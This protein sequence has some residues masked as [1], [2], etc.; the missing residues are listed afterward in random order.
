MLLVAY[1]L[2]LERPCE[3]LAEVLSWLGIEPEA[4]MIERA[5]QNMQFSN[6]QAQEAQKP[7]NPDEFFFRRGIKGSGELELQRSTLR[8]IRRQA[9]GLTR[10][11]DS[12]IAAQNVA[13]ARHSRVLKASA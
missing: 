1:E 3:V 9:A 2:M 10:Q 12:L 8:R 5:V 13:A 11:A 4:G 6:L 7:A